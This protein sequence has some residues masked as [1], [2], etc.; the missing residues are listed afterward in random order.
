VRTPIAIA[1]AIP[2]IAIGASSRVIQKKPRAGSESTGD[3]STSSARAIDAII[4]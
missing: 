2:T 4:D 1:I 3:R